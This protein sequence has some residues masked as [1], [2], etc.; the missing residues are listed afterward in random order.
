MRLCSIKRQSYLPHHALNP[1]P[2]KNPLTM[3]VRRSTSGPIEGDIMQA[4]EAILTR[5]TV[6]PARMAAPGPGEA[7]LRRMLA[8]AAAA[9]DHGKLRPW[10]F[11]VVRGGG[12]ERLGDLFAAG[13]QAARPDTSPAEIEKQRAAPLRA[14]VILIAISRA[15]PNHPKIP[16]WE[17][18][19]SAACAVQ[20][21]L[22][23]AHAMGFAGKWASG[24][25][26]AAQAVCTGLGLAP[27]ERII[28][29][30]YLGSPMDRQSLPPRPAP[31]AIA[32]S[33]P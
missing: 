7:A 9:P 15:D 18:E 19:A 24:G 17:Q 26:A 2:V 21:L 31:E 6:P 5:V 1:I 32:E 11:L 4:L 28:G 20:N 8:A 10:R 22:L 29:I 27:N 14:P 13:V 33:W 25:P 23:A 16:L 30:I 3:Q 12:R